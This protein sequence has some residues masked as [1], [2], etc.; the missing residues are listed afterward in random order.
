M[1]GMEPCESV[2]HLWV[3]ES[4]HHRT[5]RSVYDGSEVFR[6]RLRFPCFGLLAFEADTAV[7]DST[8]TQAIGVPPLLPASSS[9]FPDFCRMSSSR[10]QA[11]HLLPFSPSPVVRTWIL[12][13]LLTSDSSIVRCRT[14]C[15][16][17]VHLRDLPVRPPRVSSHAFI[18]YTRRIYLNSFG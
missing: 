8:L 16:F 4:P 18:P 6:V 10:H 7:D 2:W 12:W 15:R 14:G 17:E 11:T 3:I 5:Y 1:A 9:G 13:P